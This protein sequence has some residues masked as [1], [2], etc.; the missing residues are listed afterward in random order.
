MNKFTKWI[1]NRL[2]K[3]PCPVQTP[4]SGQSGKNINCYS[5]SIYDGDSPIMLVNSI[6]SNGIT[7]SHF[8][9]G[10]FRTEAIIPFLLYPGLRLR[11]E[12]YHGLVTHTYKGVC[13]YMLHEW[14]WFYKLQ[15]FY[16]LAKHSVPQ[17]FFNKKNLQLPKRMKVLESIIVKQSEDPHKSF[18]SLDL[19]SYMYSIRWYLHPQKTEMRKKM[20]LYLSSFVASGELKNNGSSFDFIIT[21]KAIAT[22]EQYQIETAR[23][24]SAKSANSWMLRLTAILAFFAAFQSGVIVSPAWIDL[25][26]ICGWLSSYM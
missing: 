10:G 3:K 22:L 24:K 26:K 7:G 16:V 2:L 8:E 4:R 15:S 14:T 20:D 19:M 12:H 1:L 5:I 23:A 25:G 11:I 18:S 9:G 21:G 6:E 13:D 17:Y